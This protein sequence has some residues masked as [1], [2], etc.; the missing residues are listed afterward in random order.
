[1]NLPISG[2]TKEKT[3]TVISFHVSSQIVILFFFLCFIL[4]CTQ[5]NFEGSLEGTWEYR[6]GFDESWLM[7]KESLE[8]I[9]VDLPLNLKTIIRE[10]GNQET[11][12][13]CKEIPLNI[14][15]S[16]KNNQNLIFRSGQMSN[17]ADFYFNT[18]YIGSL[19][20]SEPAYV[21]TGD[22]YITYLPSGFNPETRKNYIFMVIHSS[23]AESVHGLIGRNIEIGKSRQIYSHLYARIIMTIIMICIYF[24]IGC[25]FIYVGVRIPHK[26]SYIYYGAYCLLTAFFHFIYYPAHFFLI[27]S[28][29]LLS[30]T[31]MH[32]AQFLSAPLLILFIHAL[33]TKGLPLILKIWTAGCIL[34]AFVLLFLRPFP[35]DILSVFWLVVWIFVLIYMVVIMT[36]YLQRNKKEALLI[37][38][39]L[40][41]TL[42]SIVFDF[43][44]NEGFINHLPIGVYTSFFAISLFSIAIISRFIQTYKK[45]GYLNVELEMRMEERTKRLEAAQEKLIDTAHKAG[46]A[47][48]ATSILHNLRNIL[49]SMSIACEEITETLDYSRLEGLAKANDLLRDYEKEIHTFL[50]QDPKG[51]LLITYYLDIEKMLK[52][53][54]EK[55]I[56]ETEQI[57]KNLIMVK[58]I[59]DIQQEYAKR[60]LVENELDLHQTIEEAIKIQ[61]NEFIQTNV[62]IEKQYSRLPSIKGQKACVIQI[63]L[64]IFKNACT[65]MQQ[66]EPWNRILTIKTGIKKEKSIF[67]RIGDNGIG[68]RKEDLEKIFNFGFTNQENGHGFGLHACADIINKMGGTITA[69]S[70]G[71]GKG[72]SFTL[73]FPFQTIIHKKNVT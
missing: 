24:L 60:E 40:S 34:L 22:E 18:T 28:D 42:F 44:S 10:I 64:N 7:E 37:I 53:E 5:N 52:E 12:T 50:T 26:L 8:W 55:I 70:N 56:T 63:L 46:M 54:H 36:Q 4:S 59:I 73:Y 62:V 51:T 27:I 72:A 69:Q 19:Q 71:P 31:L 39:G 17:A 32:A 15:N 21:D 66:N 43:L 29:H 45:V 68:I 65:A 41:I 16:F 20:S 1:M 48:V 47:E 33:H 6:T 3:I 58:K 38:M 25:Y 14:I 23:G 9:T 49:N 11:I 30:Y 61:N 13:L 35:L 67:I 57:K 2:C